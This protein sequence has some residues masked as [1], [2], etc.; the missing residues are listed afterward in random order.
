MGEALYKLDPGTMVCSSGEFAIAGQQWSIEY[1][2]Q[3]DISGVI[4]GEALA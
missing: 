3:S 4:R 2:C 1:F